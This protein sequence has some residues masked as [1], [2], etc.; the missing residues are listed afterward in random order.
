M[1]MIGS[2]RHEEAFRV[3]EAI[4]ASLNV[5]PNFLETAKRNRQFSV[6]ALRA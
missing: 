6:D 5:P 2:G 1:W 4:L 3:N